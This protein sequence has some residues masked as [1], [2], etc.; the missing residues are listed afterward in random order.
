MK[1]N[2]RK[3]I[4]WNSIGSTVNA[5][6]SLF[7]LIIVT[8][9]NGTKIGGV[10]TFSYSLACLLQVIITYA[11]RPYQVTEQ[12]KK[13]K[14]SDFF[15]SRILTTIVT[16]IIVSLFVLI[17]GY[18]LYKILIIF[19]AVIY[20]ASDGISDCLYAVLQKKELLHKVGK[21]LLLKGILCIVSFITT[22]I[23]TKSILVSL[24]V[25]NIVNIIICYFYDYRSTLK[26]GFKIEKPKKENIISILKG[27]FSVFAFTILIQYL[28]SA[29][30]Y[31]IDSTLSDE[32]QTIYGIILMPA[33]VVVLISQ[34]IVQPYLTTISNLIKENKKKELNHLILKM[35]IYILAFSIASILAAYLIGTQV[36]SIIYG[37]KLIKYKIDLTFIL[38][39]ASLFAL[40]YVL[41]SVM[42]ALRINYTQLIIYIVV[43]VFAYF[44]SI[45]FVNNYKIFGASLAY[46]LSMILLFIMYTTT[47]IFIKK[48]CD[49]N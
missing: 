18:K 19:L 45:Y 33:T 39:G 35:M 44:E 16:F 27:G 5:C 21:S 12:N 10:F 3:N 15:H 31:T 29:Q 41:S 23:L 48:G 8:R 1:D 22:D 24:I 14:D 9:I 25:L 7:L 38:I 49:K 43:S 20:R 4:I 37:V 2:L 40:S 46:M 6:T 42:L 26:T 13:I 32:F 17:R 34:F 36:L 28:V 11:G 30:K 47:Y